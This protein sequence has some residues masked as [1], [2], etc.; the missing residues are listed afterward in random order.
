[1]C[2]WLLKMFNFAFISNKFN[3]ISIGYWYWRILRLKILIEKRKKNNFL[4]FGYYICSYLPVTRIQNKKIEELFSVIC[5]DKNLDLVFVF[6][7]CWYFFQALWNI[8]NFG[9]QYVNLNKI[10]LLSFYNSVSKE[11]KN[12]FIIFSWN[13]FK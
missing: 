2:R 9:Q 6:I 13:N 3:I 1:M 11:K 8:I 10:D 7:F 5:F 4:K 12:I